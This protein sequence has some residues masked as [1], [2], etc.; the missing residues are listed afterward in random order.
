MSKLFKH[1]AAVVLAIGLSLA[2]LPGFA[3]ISPADNLVKD[4]DFRNTV[5][6]NN[7]RELVDWTLNLLLTP[8]G[9]PSPY[10]SWDSIAT[11]DYE[12][13]GISNFLWLL[14]GDPANGCPKDKSQSVQQEI[15]GLVQNRQYLL[16]FY[17]L[18]AAWDAYNYLTPG[19]IYASLGSEVSGPIQLPYADTSI[20]NS[21]TW[22]FQSVKFTYTGP[23]GS[24]LLK[25]TQFFAGSV[26]CTPCEH[27]QLANVLLR[28]VTPKAPQLSVQKAMG[29]NRVADTD[30]FT[31][32]I[33]NGS[34]VVNSTS[35]STTTG[36]GATV[37]PGSGTT[38]PT[39]LVAGTSYVIKEVAS[40]ST[41]LGRYARALACT[42]STGSNVPS[43][44]DTPFTLAD[45]DTVSCTLTNSPAPVLLSLRQMVQSTLALT[46]PPPYSFNYSVNNGWG[47]QVL[48]NTSV[49]TF[50]TS[51]TRALSAADSATTV[52]VDLPSI[53]W[54]VTSLSC[55][56]SNAAVSGNPTGTLVST[57]SS[58]VTVPAQYVRP[59]ANLQCTSVLRYRRIR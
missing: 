23:S 5:V 48:S 36:S 53:N 35:N 27:L 39:T 34:T 20:P 28:D 13:L 46:A 49:N 19:P 22:H 15:Q 18:G 56:D 17:A 40:G 24:A 37:T 25:L 4:W 55:I 7:K 47:S 11:T 30:Q 42:N 38:G 52:S 43:A 59:G 44:L 2:A 6:V 45:T 57:L 29:G 16:T 8:R 31:L 50:T 33:L 32:Q 14:C 41:N 54:A 51:P 3:G 1:L 9:L 21:V 12:S 26:G 10:N 58:S